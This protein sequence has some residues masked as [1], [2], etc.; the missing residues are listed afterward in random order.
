MFA[1][2][3]RGEG[4]RGLSQRGKIRSGHAH[5]SARRPRINGN[6]AKHREALKPILDEGL[7]MPNHLGEEGIEEGGMGTR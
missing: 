4:R 7:V 2:K 6:R 1:N 3:T 5:L